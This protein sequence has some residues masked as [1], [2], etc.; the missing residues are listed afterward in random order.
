MKTIKAAHSGTPWWPYFKIVTAKARRD[1]HIRTI[2]LLLAFASFLIASIYVAYVLMHLVGLI[3]QPLFDRRG[4]Q[5]MDWIAPQWAW[6]TGFY[7]H[8]FGVVWVIYARRPAK[9]L[10]LVVNLG[11]FFVW[12][13]MTLSLDVALGG[14]VPSTSMEWVMVCASGWALLHTRLGVDDS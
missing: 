5:I 6:A 10:P 7:A 13:F 4:Y 2:R 1:V 14:F 8:A 11:G 9:Y 3:D 12:C